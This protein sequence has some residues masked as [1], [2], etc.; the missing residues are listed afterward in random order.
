MTDNRKFDT[1][2]C[3]VSSQPLP[4][5]IPALREETR[6][7]KAILLVSADMK[8]RAALLAE[9]FT[10]IGCQVEEVAISPYRIEEIRATVLDI[11]AK[12]EEEILALNATG[13]TKIMALGTAEVFRE[14]GRPVFYVDTDNGQFIT[15]FPSPTTSPLPE[16]V[17]IK[18]YLAAYGYTIL[19]KGSSHVA[20]DRQRVCEFLIGKADRFASAVGILNGCAA[21]AEKR[22]V[23][24]AEIEER[25]TS[26]DSLLELLN[27]LQ[28]ENIVELAGRR[29]T[30]ADPEARRFVAGGWL[31]EYVTRVVCRLKGAKVIHDH[32]CN[33]EVETRQGV[34]NEIDVA[35]T[36]RNRLHLIECKSGRL[37]E[38]EGK[39]SRA[40]GVAYKLD[41]L[42]D[43]MGGTYGK[44]MLVSYR[45][46]TLEDRRRCALNNI[47]IVENTDLP[48][49]EK[50]LRDWIA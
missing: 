40:D 35:F 48:G 29:I 28:K 10:K 8:S 11:L 39:E 25:H 17:R 15:L 30:F 26:F 14:F 24:W 33:L 19:T 20:P 7:R 18:S 12:K 34:R 31:E 41:N 43:L 47:H 1:H 6:P 44:A 38:K 13:G 42:R 2:L 5:L 50:K 49:L 27:L 45:K 4:N 23:S 9:N 32:L 3:L 22:E 21:T 37:S 46:L 16:V 36:A